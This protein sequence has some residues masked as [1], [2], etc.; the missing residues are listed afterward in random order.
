MSA[1]WGWVVLAAVVATSVIVVEA[2]RRLLA[3]RLSARW[4]GAGRVA[5][6]VAAPAFA[7][8]AVVSTNAAMPYHLLGD[9]AEGAV[10]HVL[11][12]A[13]IG[14]ST[15]LLLR[16]VYALSDPPLERLMHIEGERNRRARRVRTQMLLLRRI[17]AVVIV[18]LAV[19]A[20]LFTFPGVRAIGAGVLASAGVAGLVVGIAA[21][22]T[23]G[24]LLAGLQ[25]AFSDALRLDD[26][27][28]VDGNWGRVEELT[29]S[30]VVLRLW[31]DRRMIYP[32]S[33]FT[34]Q[35]FENWTR[36][37]SRLLGS[38]ELHVDWSVPVDELRREL[39]S[40]LKENPLW[41]RREWILQ[42]VDVQPNGLVT[43]RALMS[44]AD[45]ASTWDLRCDMRE[46]LVSYIR[47]NHPGALPR[48]RVGHEDGAVG[49][50]PDGAQPDGAQPDG[51]RPDG[52]RAD[53]G[54]ADGR[55][56]AYREVVGG[57]A[58]GGPGDGERAARREDGPREDGPR[59]DG[60][61]RPKTLRRA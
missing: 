12:I 8:A 23:L 17:A 24:N 30:Y 18:V 57:E 7:F 13:A 14:A 47:D 54:R 44:A 55:E 26:V 21:R 45:S 4:P 27:V 28:V 43:L 56:A 9:G 37:S 10:R 46:H 50:S 15:W 3:G 60:P 42:V 52:G 41:D 51:A 19:G 34:E 59:G 61:A 49:A 5:R 1:F 11:R 53:G 35:P 2:G 31:D 33:H 58:A 6:R 32:V 22:P 16:I 40:A 36:H 48:F 38:V 29:L 20:A 39:Y 25:L